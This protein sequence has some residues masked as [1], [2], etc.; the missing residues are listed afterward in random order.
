MAAKHPDRFGVRFSDELL[1]PIL[2]SGFRIPDGLTVTDGLPPDAVLVGASREG[3]IPSVT[4]WFRSPSGYPVNE[5]F[6]PIMRN[7]E[8]S[9]NYATV[10]GE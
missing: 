8:I 6:G 1:L 4:L 10:G 9:R 5:G 3:D 7:I 2:R